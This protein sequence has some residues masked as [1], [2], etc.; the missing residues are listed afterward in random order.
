MARPSSRIRWVVVLYHWAVVL[1]L[2]MSKMELR[3]E[4]ERENEKTAPRKKNAAAPPARAQRLTYLSLCVKPFRRSSAA[5]TVLYA[6][7][8]E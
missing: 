8:L 1:V 5:A 2:M 3:V 7:D 6:V 4:D